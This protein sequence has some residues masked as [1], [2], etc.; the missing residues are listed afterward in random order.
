[1][2]PDEIKL[3]NV[4]KNFEYAKISREIDSCDDLEY[5]KNLSKSYVKLY[6]KTQE[7]FADLIKM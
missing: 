5:L 3:D 6:L 4:S 1:M 2:N 7:T